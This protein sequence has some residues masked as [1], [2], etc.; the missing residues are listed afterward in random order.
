MR[1]SVAA[2]GLGTLV[3]ISGTAAPNALSGHDAHLPLKALDRLFV[4]VDRKSVPPL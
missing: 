4:E 3:S 1:A 2:S